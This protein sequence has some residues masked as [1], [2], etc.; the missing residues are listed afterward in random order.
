MKKGFTLIEL[1]ATIVLLGVIAFIAY[2]Q[3]SKSIQN[4]REKAFEETKKNIIKAAN[5][6][7]AENDASMENNGYILLSTLIESG[8]LENKVYKNPL[9]GDEI[10][11]CVEYEW[12]EEKKQYDFEFIDICP[13][14]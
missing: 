3:V 9:T 8:S 2:P 5:K 10:T 13:I 7:S 1:I 12:Q 4:S 6:Y 11:G 14:R